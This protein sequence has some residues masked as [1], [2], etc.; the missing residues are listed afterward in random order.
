MNLI[1]YPNSF[2]DKQVKDFD[3]ENPPVDPKELKKNMV[4]IMLDSNGIGL[5]AN[6]VEFDGQVFVMGDKEDN[7]TICINPKILQHTKETVMDMEGCL[8]FPGVYVNVTLNVF[9]MNGITYKVLPLR[10]E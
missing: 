7:S 10:I 6:Q 1:Y 4:Q 8:S 9:Y 3:I 2:L 5:S